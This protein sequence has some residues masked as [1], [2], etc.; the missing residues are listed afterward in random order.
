LRNV[1]TVKLK[2]TE[3]TPMFEMFDWRPD[4]TQ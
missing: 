1:R 4:S 3:Q 2:K